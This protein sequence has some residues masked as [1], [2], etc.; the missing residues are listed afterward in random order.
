MVAKINDVAKEAR[1]S[2]ATV[3]RV[4]NNVPIVNGATKMRVEEAIKKLNY[5]PNAIAR[6]L[7]LQK[8]NTIGVIIDDVTRTFLTLSLHGIEQQCEKSGY[9]IILFNTYP[10][11]SQEDKIIELISQKQCDGIIFIGLSMSD[12]LRTILDEAN[13]PVVVG[14]LDE[15]FFTSV[16]VNAKKAAYD[17]VS[18]FASKGHKKIGMIG[19]SEDDPLST[20]HIEGF[21]QALFERS[22]EINPK[23]LVKGNQDYQGG[24]KAMYGLIDSSSFPSAVYCLSD[25]MACGAIRAVERAGYKVPDDVSIIGSGN[26]PISEWNNPAIT[27]IGLDHIHFGNELAKA[28][29]SELEANSQ[30]PTPSINVEHSIIERDSVKRL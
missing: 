23:Y 19:A 9:N 6:S 8:T 10:G 21:R 30:E 28:L 3:S 12:K 29:F 15:E 20:A 27:T 17:A 1:V 25:E 18:Y 14:Y 4:I 13:F 11:T 2:I 16:S 26:A 7:K 22:L 24:Y 5:K